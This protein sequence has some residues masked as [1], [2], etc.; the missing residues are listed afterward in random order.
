[1]IEVKDTPIEGLKLVLPALFADDRGYFT[2]VY[3]R[4]HY[5]R[6]GIDD[7]FVQDNDALSRKGVLRGLHYQTGIHG[8]SKLVRVTRGAVW[9]VAVD[10]RP[11]SPTIGQWYGVEL[12]ASNRWQL[13]IPEGFAHGYVALE[14]DT[15]FS[16]KCGN[17]YAPQAEGGIVYNDPIIGIEW[18]DPGIPLIISE[19]DR[20]L[21]SFGQHRPIDK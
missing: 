16:Y 19:K 15:L 6:H 11:D 7:N 8:Q 17:L 14:D 3:H 21:P 20:I 2:M 10:L 12:S 13:Y 5:V 1:M 4:E 9:D 18:P